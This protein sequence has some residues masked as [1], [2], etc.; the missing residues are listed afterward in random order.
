MDGCLT[1]ALQKEV[2]PMNAQNALTFLKHLCVLKLMGN[3]P[4]ITYADNA[5]TAAGRRH[6]RNGD[7]FG[8]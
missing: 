4:L 7:S 2:M 8:H 3:G 5:P 1:E 6:R